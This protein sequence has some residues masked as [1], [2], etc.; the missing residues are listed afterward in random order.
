MCICLG[1]YPSRGYRV[2]FELGGVR[3]DPVILPP[4]LIPTLALH[5]PKLCEH[6][7]RGGQYK[8]NE[9]SFRMQTVVGNSARIILDHTS[10]SL[11]LNELEYLVLNPTFVA[12]HGA[13]QA[14][15]SRRISLRAEYRGSNDLR[16]S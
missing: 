1:F 5:L 8:C 10:L 16:S 12:N 2:F 6:L 15:R 11:R 3:Q 7:V 9:M 14:S 13:V 4:S